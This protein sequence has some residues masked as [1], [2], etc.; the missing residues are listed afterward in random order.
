MNR[1]K[2]RRSTTR[3]PGAVAE[4][5]RQEP[6]YYSHSRVLE[7]VHTQTIQHQQVELP[8]GLSVLT[9]SED[10][11]LSQQSTYEPITPATEDVGPT[12]TNSNTTNDKDLRRIKNRQAQ[13]AFRERRSNRIRGLEKRVEALEH[14]RKALAEENIYLKSRLKVIEQVVHLT[15]K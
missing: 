11:F 4:Q 3:L 1:A 15:L 9:D 7:P 13:R 14:E 10:D 8:Y 2:Q 12:S 6:P 5:I